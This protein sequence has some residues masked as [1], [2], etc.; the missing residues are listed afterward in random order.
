LPECSLF[1]ENFMKGQGTL[2]VSIYG[3]A[4]IEEI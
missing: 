4:S 2:A 1:H 3:L